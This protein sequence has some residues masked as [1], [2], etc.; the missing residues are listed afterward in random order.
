MA[1]SSGELAFSFFA[2]PTDSLHLQQ[3]VGKLTDLTM[4]FT[5]EI[6][7]NLA[8]HKVVHVPVCPKL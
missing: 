1:S 7:Y 3:A 6:C 2:L 4:I 5:K 8:F